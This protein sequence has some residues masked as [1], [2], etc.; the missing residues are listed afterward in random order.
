MS[1]VA[2]SDAP[3]RRRGTGLRS[4]PAVPWE[5]ALAIALMLGAWEW[6]SHHST[7]M[8]FPSL[9]QIAATAGDLLASPEGWSAVAITYGR[10]WAYLLASFLVSSLLG[11]AVAGNVHVERFLVPLVELKQGIPSLCWVIFAILWFRDA[12]ARIAF[13]VVT[14]A[15]PAFFYQARDAL[16]GIPRDWVDLVQSMRP[17]PWQRARILWWPA[18]LPSL[19]TVWRINIGNA[20]RVTIMAEL[21]GG[22]TGIGHQL[23]VSQE[24]FR[25]DQTIVWTAVLV[26]FVILSNQVLSG[27]ERRFLSYR[28]HDGVRS[29]A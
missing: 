25:M 23:R 22:I 20:T 28:G 24:M 21:L 3:V 5:G 1:S 29:H 6:A 10:I 15:L 27:F 9:S 12:E 2:D 7:P 4:W 16:R 13:V 17:T 26:A 19:L 11:A 8:F 14:S 18:V